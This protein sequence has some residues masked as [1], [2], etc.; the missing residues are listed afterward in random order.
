MS[1]ALLILAYLLG[2]I[3]TAVWVSKWFFDVDV[4]TLGSGNAGATN[5]ARTLGWR[6]ALPV[7]LVD[8]GKGA[9]AA[10]LP[11]LLLER[12]PA[13]LPL[14]CAGAAVLGHTFPVFAGFSG[15]KGVATAGGALLVLAPVLM[16]IAA[17]VWVLSV[18]I[19]RIVSLASL[20]AGVALA[21]SAFGLPRVGWGMRPLALF[22][23]LFVCWTHRKNLKRLFAGQ[24][25]RFAFGKSPGRPKKLAGCARQ[26]KKEEVGCVRWR[27]GLGP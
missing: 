3:P 10:G 18:C 8:V 21:V 13:W 16:G 6:A 17:G 23:C 11:S 2:S 24:E 19:T 15:G 26:E 12:A 14:A 27:R 5:V 7:V 25:P 1:A 9:L 22:L 4:R 20:L